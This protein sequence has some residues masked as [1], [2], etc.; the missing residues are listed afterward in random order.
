MK[1][2]IITLLWLAASLALAQQTAVHWYLPTLK[3]NEA[4]TLK[5][6]DCF[7]GDPEV[8]FS[9]PL[10]IDLLKQE[11]PGIKL[12]CY[13][14]PTEWFNPMFPDKPWSIKVVDF[15]NKVPQWWLKG[16]DGK[17]ISFWPGMQT[18]NCSSECPKME[19]NGVKMNYMEFISQVFID[20]I[21]KKH[22]FDGI[23]DDNDWIKIFWLGHR[24]PNEHGICLRD[25]GIKT[26]SAEADNSWKQGRAYFDEAVRKAMGPDFI[27]IGNP[28]N[29]DYLNACNGKI[30]ENFSDIYVNE[31]DT[32]YQAW[33]DNLN[34]ATQMKIAIFNARKDNAWFTLCS[35]MLL[36]N[37]I[38]SYSQNAPYDSSWALDLG[39]PTGAAFPAGPEYC[40]QFQNGTVYVNPLLQTA[41]IVYKDG[42]VRDK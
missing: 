2:Y 25:N 21:L 30:F 6:Y 15:L 20:N 22:K 12:L 11:N 33:Y 41:R 8:F 34:E 40:R 4:K 35:S 17:R 16:T 9:S 24:K 3:I 27:I 26:D 14:N 28:A 1:K 42:T 18:M 32:I 38:F 10:A 23:V 31:K 39:R 37:V 29:L 7:I 19:I 13:F 36:N 5:G